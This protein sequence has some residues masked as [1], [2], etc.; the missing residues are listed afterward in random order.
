[1][2]MRMC[3]ARQVLVHTEACGNGFCV[4]GITI[5]A[6]R[7]MCGLNK[8]GGAATL[9]EDMF[10]N[11]PEEVLFCFQEED[12]KNDYGVSFN[13]RTNLCFQKQSEKAVLGRVG[14]RFF[15]VASARIES[16]IHFKQFFISILTIFYQILQRN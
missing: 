8:C 11:E 4:C 15:V 14:I 3:V 13:P 16:K 6:G 7:D 10:H 12:N 1:M 2:S 9:S 5:W